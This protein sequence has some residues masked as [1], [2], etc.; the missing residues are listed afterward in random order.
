MKEV[1]T[2]DEAQTASHMQGSWLLLPG[3]KFLERKFEY[4]SHFVLRMRI[5]GTRL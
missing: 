4:M 1:Q 2:G 5:G 3:V